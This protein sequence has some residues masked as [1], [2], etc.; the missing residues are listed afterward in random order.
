MSSIGQT[1]MKC[2]RLGQQS[3]LSQKVGVLALN[4][5]ENGAQNTASFASAGAGGAARPGLQRHEGAHGH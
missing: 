2:N 1:T 4:E 5:C 3:S